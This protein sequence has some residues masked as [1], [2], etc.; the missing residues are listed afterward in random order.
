MQ[1]SR[2][3][4]KSK[5]NFFDLKNLNDSSS[6]MV[7][8]HTYDC[9][10][11]WTRRGTWLFQMTCPSLRL[12]SHT[13]SLVCFLE[14]HLTRDPIPSNV[15][16][17]Y[18]VCICK[19]NIY[20]VKHCEKKSNSIAQ[21]LC[22]GQCKDPTLHTLIVSCPWFLSTI[23]IHQFCYVNIDTLAK[24][25]NSEELDD[26]EIVQITSYMITN[27]IFVTWNL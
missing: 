3:L 22:F 8:V 19:V 2:R 20:W 9:T 23:A 25:S 21:H 24:F 5:P 1:H 14:W 26:R 12:S 6:L 15:E 13:S 4:R 10:N 27:G 11:G 18:Q 7:V 16:W 17:A